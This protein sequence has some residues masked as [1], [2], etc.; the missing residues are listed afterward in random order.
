M[1]MRIGSNRILALLALL[2]LGWI[3]YRYFA[4]SGPPDYSGPVAGWP[5]YGNDPGGTRYSPLTQ[6]TPD[7]VADL[8][9]AWTYH[10]GDFSGGSDS[11]PSRSSFQATPILLD[12]VLYVSTPFSRVIA[13]DP[14]TG[15][16]L[17]THDPKIDL[18]IRYSENL[19]SRGVAAWTSPDSLERESTCGRRILF[20]TLDARLLALDAKTGAPCSDFGRGGQVDLRPGVEGGHGIEP[21]QYEVTS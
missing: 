6:I 15:E 8:E 20:G 1:E 17:W 19:V 4:P 14:E 11:I 21:G 18:S 7:N 16:E 5:S 9:I 13:L 3:G 2:A 10:T 12:G